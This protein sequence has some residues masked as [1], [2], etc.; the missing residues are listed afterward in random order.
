MSRNLCQSL[1]GTLVKKNVSFCSVFREKQL[2]E[3]TLV[4][5]FFLTSCKFGICVV[6][7]FS[8][9]D[10][11]LFSDFYD[12]P[13]A[14]CVWDEKLL[15][16]VFNRSQSFSLKV[17]DYVWRDL[18]LNLLTKTN[19]FSVFK[20]FAVSTFKISAL[21]SFHKLINNGH[22]KFGFKKI[23]KYVNVWIPCKLAPDFERNLYG[24][25]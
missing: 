17:W 15:R 1:I 20:M 11:T 18:A 13:A 10:V 5:V 3:I 12:R 19:F 8:S 23:S 2:C 21:K 9:P 14:F 25:G 4:A 24:L 22:L 16:K 7:P 6:Q